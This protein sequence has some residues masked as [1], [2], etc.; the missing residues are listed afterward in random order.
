LGGTLLRSILYI[1]PQPAHLKLTKTILPVG[2][3]AGFTAGFSAAGCFIGIKWPQA[4]HLTFLM[5]RGSLASLTV[6]F[7]WQFGQVMFIGKS[8][9]RSGVQGFLNKAKP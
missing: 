6:Y 8:V 9:Q 5:P 4:L 2:G 1:L 3:P 7:F